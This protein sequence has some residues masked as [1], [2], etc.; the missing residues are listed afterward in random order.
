MDK[1]SFWSILIHWDNF[2]RLI[3]PIIDRKSQEQAH[4]SI[5]ISEDFRDRVNFDMDA[6]HLFISWSEEAGGDPF[7]NDYNYERRSIRIGFD[8]LSEI[9]EG[10]PDAGYIKKLKERIEELEI[11]LNDESRWRREAERSKPAY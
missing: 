11:R 8:E 2:I 7:Y 5:D 6:D 1:Q 10:L 3:Q 9:S 4:P